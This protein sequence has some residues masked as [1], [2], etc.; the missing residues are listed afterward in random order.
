MIKHP[1]ALGW[2]APVTSSLPSATAVWPKS[3]IHTLQA[4]MP[5]DVLLNLRS[6]GKKAP[7]YTIC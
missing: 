2:M 7:I 1:Y 6:G 5:S 4:T 3:G